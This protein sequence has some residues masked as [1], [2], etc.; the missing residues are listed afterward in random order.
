MHIYFLVYSKLKAVL[1]VHKL[2]QRADEPAKY[3]ITQTVSS[4]REVHDSKCDDTFFSV[5]L[6][7]ESTSVA[8]NV[9]E[10][11]AANFARINCDI[12]FSLACRVLLL[13]DKFHRRVH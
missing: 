10:I 9:A 7:E 11:Q 2:M 5:A 12:A 4:L 13:I 8:S 3:A 6:I 1:S